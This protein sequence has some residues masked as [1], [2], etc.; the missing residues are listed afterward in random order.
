MY[1]ISRVRPSDP[2]IDW[3]VSDK[4]RIAQFLFRYKIAK[5]QPCPECGSESESECVA[6]PITNNRELTRHRLPVKWICPRSNCNGEQS[7]L[8]GS[9]LY[10]SHLSLEKHIRLLY[11]FY[12]QRNALESK[13]EL[14][15]NRHHTVTDWFDWYCLYRYGS[16]CSRSCCTEKF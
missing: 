7:F 8:H 2:W 11:K 13:Q 3:L 9:Y 10:R 6:A 4:R 5:P 15:C 16:C 14:E 12:L 1:N